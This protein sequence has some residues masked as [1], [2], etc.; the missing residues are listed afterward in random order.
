MFYSYREYRA[1]SAYTSLP[2]TPVYF[3]RIFNDAA[4]RALVSL[5]TVPSLFSAPRIFCAWRVNRR[6]GGAQGGGRRLW[7]FSVSP[8]ARR[9]D[10]FTCIRRGTRNSDYGVRSSCIVSHDVFCPVY[11]LLLSFFL[12]FFFSGK[13]LFPFISV[14]ARLNV[15]FTRLF[16]GTKATKKKKCHLVSRF[17]FFLET[18]R[19]TNRNEFRYANTKIGAPQQRWRPLLGGWTGLNSVLEKLTERFSRSSPKDVFRN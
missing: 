17:L 3:E 6:R 11:S 2:S 18:L 4:P 16:G 14:T 7:S 9:N 19:V 12:S 10:N 5:G 13:T 15:I 8:R 1:F